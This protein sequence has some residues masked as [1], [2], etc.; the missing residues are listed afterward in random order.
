M[1]VIALRQGFYKGAR[2]REG[3]EIEWDIR[4]SIPRWVKVKD[5]MAEPKPPEPEQAP[6]DWKKIGRADEYPAQNKFA[7]QD[8]RK[9]T[10][11]NVIK[12]GLGKLK[13]AKKGKTSGA[14]KKRGD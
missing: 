5:P 3:E 4:D 13:T 2:Y 8:T 7:K 6:P 9:P 12:K 1:I 10:P 14:I 11:G